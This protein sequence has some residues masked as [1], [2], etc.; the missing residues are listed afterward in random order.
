MGLLVY[1]FYQTCILLIETCTPFKEG[2]DLMKTPCHTIHVTGFKPDPA[3]LK[4]T[5]DPFKAVLSMIEPM[6]T[7]GMKK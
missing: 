4:Q 2:I 1:V 5:K 6:K 3:K 7:G